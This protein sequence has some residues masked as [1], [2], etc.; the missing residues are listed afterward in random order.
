M[1]GEDDKDEGEID[2][3]APPEHKDQDLAVVVGDK[4]EAAP[5][6]VA[7]REEPKVLCLMGGMTHLHC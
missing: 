1:N 3:P 7:E 4:D 6:E 5:Q 2:P